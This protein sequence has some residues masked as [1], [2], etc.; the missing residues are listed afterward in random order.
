MTSHTQSNIFDFIP[1][2]AMIQT[3]Q[4]SDTVIKSHSDSL[5]DYENF[6]FI[7]RIELLRKMQ[8][9]INKGVLI[10]S[11]KYLR[12]WLHR[13]PFVEQDMM[14]DFYRVRAIALSDSA[15]FLQA[16]L[17]GGQEMNTEEF[18]NTCDALGAYTK[19]AWVRYFNNRLLS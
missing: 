19:S 8:D 6:A 13:K 4:K 15:L 5:P 17:N 18:L 1:E 16:Y 11:D 7:E 14:Q 2:S 3:P 9:L 12:L 10:Q